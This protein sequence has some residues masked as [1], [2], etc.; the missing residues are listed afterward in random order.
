MRSLVVAALFGLAFAVPAQEARRA[1]AADACLDAKSMEAARRLRAR[2]DEGAAQ[3]RVRELL[4]RQPDHFEARAFLGQQFFAGRWRLPEEIAYLR[5]AG[6]AEAVATAPVPAKAPVPAAVPAPLPAA[7]REPLQFPLGAAAPRSRPRPRS[8]AF[9]MFDIRLQ[10][11]RLLGIDTVPV[12][13]GNGNG[14]R[15]QLPRTES[16]SFGGAV[17]LPLGLLQ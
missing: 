7:P 4:E 2:G 3:A 6:R 9:G 17:C 15:L 12:S 13:F 11:V 16:V 14:G 10:S 5:R 8:A 1:L